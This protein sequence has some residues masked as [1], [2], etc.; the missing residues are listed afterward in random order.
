MADAGVFAWREKYTFEIWRPLTGVREHPSGLG[1]PFF[2]TVGSPETNNNGISFKPPFPAY[3]SGHAT[4]GGATFQMARLYYKRRD[5]LGFADDA[6]DD[7]CI[8][9]VSDELNGINRDLREDYDPAR[10]ITE[11]VGT[12]RTRVPVR[13][14]SLWEV[15]H[16]NALSR[17][18]LGVHWRFDAFAAQ[19]VLVPNPNQEPGQSPYALNPDGSTRYKPTA[20]VRYE[21]RATRF[22]RDGLFPIGGVPLGIG[23]ADDI[24][25]ANLRPTPESEQPGQ[26]AT[27]QGLVVGLGKGQKKVNGAA[28]GTNGTK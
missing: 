4:F 27:T 17:V 8:E 25:A 28:N 22:D 10:P 1:D 7:I 6:P 19:D 2:Q 26:T 5:G 12:V 23:I 3:P 16:E 15:M 13:F 18:F 9:F 21:T 20:D 11:Q 24:F 14:A